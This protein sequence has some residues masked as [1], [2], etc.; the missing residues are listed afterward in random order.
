[1]DHSKFETLE[2]LKGATLIDKLSKDFKILNRF[3]MVKLG[4]P[5]MSYATCIDL[6]ILMK[7]MTEYEIPSELQWK[8]I[9][10]L[11]KTKYNLPGSSKLFP[12]IN[13]KEEN[14]MKIQL[15]SK[16]E[17]KG[18]NFRNICKSHIL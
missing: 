6:E 1:M 17:D 12:A 14:Q 2:G 18:P 16:D 9:V 11:G 3:K 10:R 7:E 15:K 4:L 5:V 8:E 13:K